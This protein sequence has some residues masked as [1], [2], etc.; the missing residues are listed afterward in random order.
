M[1]G[2]NKQPPRIGVVTV[3][4]THCETAWLDAFQLSWRFVP[5]ADLADSAHWKDISL[6]CLPSTGRLDLATLTSLRDFCARGGAIY[7]EA[8]RLADPPHPRIFRKIFGLVPSNRVVLADHERLFSCPTSH[9]VLSGWPVRSI[10]DAFETPY[11][12]VRQ[13][14]GTALLRGGLFAGTYRATASKESFPALIAHR[15]GKGRSLYAVFP[16]SEFQT[17]G[18]APFSRWE[19]LA[20]R[21]L[22]FLGCQPNRQRAGKT[23]ASG[24]RY[25]TAASPAASPPKTAAMR[26]TLYRETIKNNLVWFEN[27]G[28]LPRGDGGDGVLEAVEAHTGRL[29]YWRRTD[30]NVQCAL[31]FHLTGKL[32]RRPALSK[33]SRNLWE[34]LNRNQYQDTHPHSPTRGFWAWHQPPRNQDFQI[35]MDDNSWAA[36]TSFWFHR[37]TGEDAFLR[38]GVATADAFLRLR[39]ANGLHWASFTAGEVHRCGLDHFRTGSIP[40]GDYYSAS[41][42]FASGIITAMAWA[43]AFTGRRAYW[44]CATI[45]CRRVL[46]HFPH[47]RRVYYFSRTQA[48]VRLLLPL[49]VLHHIEPDDEWKHPLDDILTRL[50]AVTTS[51]GALQE[52]HPLR[53]LPGNLDIPSATRDG[54]P[55]CDLLY[56]MNFALFNL[57]FVDQLTGHEAAR[58]LFQR[59]ADYVCRIQMRSADPRLHGG[60]ARSFDYQAGEYYGSNADHGWG[61]YIMESG[62]TNAIIIAALALHELNF[63]LS[64]L[65]PARTGKRKRNPGQ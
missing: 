42:H 34:F 11:L 52:R 38:Q 39:H 54:E 56:S 20:A 5:F 45:A 48:D 24:R 23:L 44:E 30:C 7:G 63:P 57:C 8:C 25:Q 2:A 62:W 46:A 33:R 35:W 16:F 18:F 31:A 9:P 12:L 13:Q 27:S 37:L 47:Y 36:L 1:T 60:W 14:E 10:L 49:A 26:S 4:G 6:L 3:E 53:A 22:S 58:P 59:L 17:R 40:K 28:L 15:V 64:N 43:Y 65:L 19:D 51:Y 29:R 32:L 61:P 41:T 50:S 55:I 21:L